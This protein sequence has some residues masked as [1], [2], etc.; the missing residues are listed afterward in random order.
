MY[1]TNGL[2]QMREQIG[3]NV[4]TRYSTNSVELLREL[5]TTKGS[6][7]TQI[8]AYTKAFQNADEVQ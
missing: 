2:K 3:R 1:L 5:A 8:D 7:D 4:I 6:L